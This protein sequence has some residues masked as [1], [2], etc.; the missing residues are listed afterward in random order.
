MG[1][2]SM[3]IK[4]EDGE[5]DESDVSRDSASL[6]SSP[7]DEAI[8]AGEPTKVKKVKGQAIFF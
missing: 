6:P 7:N 5:D 1:T 2:N 4:E 3:D 8:G